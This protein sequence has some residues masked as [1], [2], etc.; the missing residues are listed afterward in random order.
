[1]LSRIRRF[2]LKPLIMPPERKKILHVITG[3]DIGGAEMNLTRML[4]ALEQ[5]HTNVVCC[6][7]DRGP[8]SDLL[9]DHSIPVIHLGAKK[10]IT[11]FI[12]PSVVWRFREIIKH[13]KPD[14]II[15]YLIHADLFGRFWGRVFG[16]HKVLCWN[17]GS[18]LQWQWLSFFDRL[19][20]FLVDGYIFQTEA[21][22]KEISHQQHI[23]A[24]KTQVIPN[25]VDLLAL[26]PQS[27]R[28]ATLYSAGVSDP[29]LPTLICIANLRQGKGHPVLLRAFEEVMRESGPANLLI[30]GEGEQ[31]PLL[32]TL[33]RGQESAPHIFFLGH[34]KN[35]PALLAASD[36][37]VLPTFYEGMSNAILE[38]MLM[39]RAVVTTDIPVN[40][41]IIR[42]GFSGLL[43]AV[44]D[45]QQL[46][47]ALEHLIAH[48][49][50]RLRMAKNGRSFVEQTCAPEK[51][52][53]QL[54]NLI[55][56]L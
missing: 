10:S 54:S 45:E 53:A 37:F 6:L 36:I 46:A 26:L 2:S 44:R 34:Q 23:P 15:T 8:A 38:A 42:T 31:R 19:S 22:R 5:S 55:S 35:I 28:A 4:P 47:E 27:N 21:M 25:S 24:N 40:H 52:A 29:T 41:D 20:S 30:V 11:D 56:S 7:M 13:E 17:R 32:E 12:K 33:A 49:D 14:V 18:L 39:E 48:P 51:I 16:V 50:E 3:L 43:V 9:D 1:M